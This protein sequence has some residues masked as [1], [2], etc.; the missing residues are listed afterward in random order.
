MKKK[1]TMALE[2][3]KTCGTMDE[4]NNDCVG[5]FPGG[6]IGEGDVPQ[7]LSSGIRIEAYY[8]NQARIQELGSEKVWNDCRRGHEAR[9]DSV[10]GTVLY[11]TQ[12]HRR[13]T[14]PSA[15]ATVHIPGEHSAKSR[16]HDEP[17]QRR[18]PPDGPSRRPDPGF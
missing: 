1:I 3:H 2:G 16:I 6:S 11:F 12:V 15:C 17:H 7:D 9:L 14:R 5:R 18:G 13:H 10:F 4:A 8:I